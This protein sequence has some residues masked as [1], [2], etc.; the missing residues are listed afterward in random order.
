M[1]RPANLAHPFFAY[2][3]FKPGQLGYFQIKEFVTDVTDPSE[4]HG[5]L[6]IRD[7]LPIIDENGGA[8]VKGAL[9]RFA[10]TM[11]EEAYHRISSLE[12]D[13]HYNWGTAQSGET[14]VNVLFGRSPAKGSVPCE[15]EEWN[16]WEDPLFCAALEVVE[17]TLNYAKQFEWDLKPLFRLQMAY[18]LLWSGIERYLSL[19]Y[20]L[21]DN[22]ME[23][24]RR[25]A[26]EP[27]FTTAL[28][29]YV[30][31]PRNVYRA[32]R[33]GGKEVLDPAEPEESLRY[34]YQ[35]RSNIIHRGKGVVRDHERIK[36]SLSE[37]LLIFRFV[38]KA[39]RSEAQ[40]NG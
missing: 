33:P 9:L 13:K 17:E 36:S 1:D 18:L 32:D 25:L 12:P 35:I 6:L 20:H 4:I 21:G 3:I 24:V 37:M 29:Q 19:R 40:S 11:A 14:T 30:S 38:L 15:T 23:K 7:G 5:S 28:K 22:V 16:G 2:G 34:Y 39:A 10:S 8:A 26:H 27:A 31:E